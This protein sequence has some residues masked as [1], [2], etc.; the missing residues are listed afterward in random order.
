MAS[1]FTIVMDVDSVKMLLA[2]PI[3][4]TMKFKIEDREFQVVDSEE[5]AR[6]VSMAKMKLIDV[7]Q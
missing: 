6:I 3:I 5:F 1:K 7:K 2:M 4:Q